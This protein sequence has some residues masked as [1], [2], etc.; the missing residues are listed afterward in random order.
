MNRS[1]IREHSLCFLYQI[2]VQRTDIESQLAYFVE[3]RGLQDE[4]LTFFNTLVN[5]V[6]EK[7]TEIDEKIIKF[8]VDWKLERLPILDRCILRMATFEMLYLPDIPVPV[9]IS[10]AINL[11]KKYCNEGAYSYIN[12]VLGNLHREVQ[13]HGDSA[14]QR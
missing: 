1:E 4:D 14:T 3:E 2:S 10:E 13:G 7:T 6:R 5:G 8:L 11:A 9:S 12:A